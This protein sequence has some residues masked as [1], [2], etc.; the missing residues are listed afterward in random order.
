MAGSTARA[1]VSL[2]LP[3]STSPCPGLARLYSLPPSAVY[4]LRFLLCRL[5]FLLPTSLLP[6][7]LLRS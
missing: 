5:L 2:P 4:L 6:S 7:S 3:A 1:G